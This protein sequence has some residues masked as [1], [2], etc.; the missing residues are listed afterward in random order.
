MKNSFISSKTP[1]RDKTSIEN[2]NIF[3]RGFLNSIIIEENK[4]KAMTIAI[5]RRITSGIYGT[6]N[7]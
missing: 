6:P 4:N 1:R 5:Q 7:N 3:F 2:Q